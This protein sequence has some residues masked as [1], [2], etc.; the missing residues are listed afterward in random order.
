M[1][2]QEIEIAGMRGFKAGVEYQ[3][4]QSYTEQ[5][6]ITLL[7]KRDDDL[8]YWYVHKRN[9]YPHLTDWFEE[10]KKK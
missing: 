4:E 1:T 3:K 9:N 7:E 8:D 5:E 2:Q 6:V 10:Y